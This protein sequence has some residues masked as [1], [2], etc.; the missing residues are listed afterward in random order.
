[1]ADNQK[2][3]RANATVLWAYPEAFEDAAAPTAA[4]LNNIYHPVDNPDG[5]V[6]DISCALLDDF[7]LNASESDTD[8]EL[9]ICD[10]G[11][12]ASLTFYNYEAELNFLRDKSVTDDGV[13]NLA[14]RLFRKADRPGIAIKRIGKPQGAAFDTDG[15][16]VISMYGLITDNP[17]DVIE[18]NAN[19]KFG[20]R[21]KTTGDLN[22]N[23]S[24]VA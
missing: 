7:T 8:D 22:T 1:M 9:T 19:A 6:F 23:Y 3:L 20:A 15:S 16:D 2:V 12:S 10:I 14:W 21:F 13:F 24:V 5:M 11:N 17:A 18:D 4:E